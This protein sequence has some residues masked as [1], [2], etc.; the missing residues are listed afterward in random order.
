MLE[1]EKGKL[2]EMIDE[3]GDN[4]FSSSA[5][6]PVREDAFDLSE[7]EK[8]KLIERDVAHILETLGMDLTDDSLSGTPKR[9]AKM[10]VKEVFGDLI[11]EG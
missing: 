4:H 8:I 3:I 11:P 6:N 2:K 9:V 10:F 1:G 7:K 5:R